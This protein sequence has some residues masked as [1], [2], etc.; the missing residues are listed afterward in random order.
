MC[1]L[2]LL[3]LVFLSQSYPTFF[4]YPF[5]VSLFTLSL[6]LCG[7]TGLSTLVSCSPSYYT[8]PLSS[9]TPL[10][11]KP[12]TFQLPFRPSRITHL[13]HRPTT[14]IHPVAAVEAP[15]KIGKL[16][17]ISSL[18][19]MEALALVDYLQGMLGVSTAEFSPTVVAMAPLAGGDAGGLSKDEAEDAKKPLE[20]TD[21]ETIESDHCRVKLNWTGSEKEKE[22]EKER[23]RLL[24]TGEFRSNEDR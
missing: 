2:S 21:T 19:L 20:V 10:K 7:N 16:D 8:T 14:T 13:T 5:L 17:E 3:S 4:F 23:N 24:K 9:I 15:E 11:T 12:S 22:K 6:S 18:T 1:L